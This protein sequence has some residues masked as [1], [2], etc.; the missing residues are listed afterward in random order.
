MSLTTA[1]KIKCYNNLLGNVNVEEIRNTYPNIPEDDV[2]MCIATNMFDI[3]EN[4]RF[5]LIDVTNDAKDMKSVARFSLETL[6]EEFFDKF[7]Y[8]LRNQQEYNKKFKQ[9]KR[10]YEQSE[11]LYENPFYITKKV[12]DSQFENLDKESEQD[13]YTKTLFYS[14]KATK[15]LESVK[16][17]LLQDMARNDND[18]KEIKKIENKCSLKYIDDEE[19]RNLKEEYILEYQNYLADEISKEELEQTKPYTMV[20]DLLRGKRKQGLDI[21]HDQM[22]QYLSLSTSIRNMYLLKDTCIE[23]V[24]RFVFKTRK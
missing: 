3:C 17:K 12:F 4:I 2:N 7:N 22:Y 16:Y 18:V 13:I 24:V 5:G 6:K 1:D 14:N 20:D 10:Q 15:E 23:Q 9:K 19:V 8:Y 21:S 11:N